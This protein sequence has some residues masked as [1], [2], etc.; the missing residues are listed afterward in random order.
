MA[1]SMRDSGVLPA[2]ETG[3]TG[4]EVGPATFGPATRQEYDEKSWGMQYVGGSASATGA[5]ILD[6]EPPSSRKRHRDIPAFLVLKPKPAD[7]DKHSLAAVLTILH[8]I[9][10]ARNILL[11]TGV[12]AESYG[13]N[14]QWWKGEPILAPGVLQ[15]LQANELVWGDEAKPNFEEELHRLMAFLDETTRSYGSIRVLADLVPKTT[16]V[17]ERAFYEMLTERNPNVVGPLCSSA[18]MAPIEGDIIDGDTARFGLVEME[19]P[20][21]N[22]DQI[23]TLYEA[24]DHL[25][26]V[27]AL[28]WH[29]ISEGCRMAV[30]TEC[31]DVIGAQFTNEGPKDS[32]EIP[33]VWY[34]ERY[35][36]S[37]KAEARTIQEHWAFTKRAL[38]K[39]RQL[40]YHYTNW[41]N[42][43]DDKVCKRRELLTGIVDEFRQHVKFLESHARFREFTKAG[44]DEESFPNLDDVPL[45]LT[46]DEQDMHRK[47]VAVLDRYEAE[48]AKLDRNLKSEWQLSI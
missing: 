22:Y 5:T 18:V 15:A 35:L 44:Y 48:L 32:I 7:A 4:Q 19:Y 2:Q 47:C 46:D 3:V 20:R 12:P 1:E 10:L 23:K 16:I 31:G 36:A 21:D 24:W 34:P 45:V 42:P 40:E 13:H 30:L 25:T 28:S 38:Y 26:W 11:Q 6:L 39:G 8:E 14:S 9:P 27:D 33:E 37:R 41:V 29:S 17:K 43:K